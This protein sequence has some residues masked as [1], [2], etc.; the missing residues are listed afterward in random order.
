[1]LIFELKTEQPVQG[2]VPKW[3]WDWIKKRR[4]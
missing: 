2:W 4:L 3:I 1:M